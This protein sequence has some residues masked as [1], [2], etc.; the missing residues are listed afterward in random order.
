M[1]LLDESR[2]PENA[3]RLEPLRMVYALGPE[4]L[5]QI[6]DKHPDVREEVQNVNKYLLP[7]LEKMNKSNTQ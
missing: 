1:F 7:A 5:Q 3:A 4:K 6:L 2:D